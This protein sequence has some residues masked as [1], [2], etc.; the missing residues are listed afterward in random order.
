MY[1]FNVYVFKQT[2][3]CMYICLECFRPFKVS[4]LGGGTGIGIWGKI[5]LKTS[6]GDCNIQSENYYS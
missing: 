6:P 1:V 2:P 5:F 3:V 4:S